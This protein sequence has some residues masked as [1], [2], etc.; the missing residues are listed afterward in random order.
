VDEC[1][2]GQEWWD[3]IQTIRGK[4]ETITTA[5]Q[6]L[7]DTANV[8]TAASAWPEATFQQGPRHERVERFLGLRKLLRKS[9]RRHTMSGITKLGVSLGMRTHHLDPRLLKEHPS[10]A[11][12]SED[13]GSDS[14]SDTDV[15]ESDNEDAKSVGRESAASEGD[16]DE[17]ESDIS[18]HLDSPTKLTRRRSHGDTMRG[19]PPS[20]KS[21]GEKEPKVPELSSRRPS[22]LN[23]A[24]EGSLPSTPVKEPRPQSSSSIPGKT[25]SLSNLSTSLKNSP[26]AS[27]SAPALVHNNEITPQKLEERFSALRMNKSRPVPAQTPER[28]ATL[29]R[30]ASMLKFSSKPVP[31]TR[32]ATEDGPGPSIMFTDTPSP[33]PRRNR[34]P[35][36]YRSSE[37]G[38]EFSVFPDHISEVSE[39]ENSPHGLSRQS[40][41][42]GSTYS[43]QGI[44]LSFNDLPCRAQHLILNELIRMQSADTAVMFTTLPSPMEGTSQSEEAC[45]SYLSDLE[46]LCKDCPP[47]LLV[48]SNSMTVTMSL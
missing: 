12:A 9:K 19:P 48:H 10:N 30:H 45:I 8:F 25:T 44:P 6:D 41:L 47:C 46:V 36:A 16:L 39:N 28:P 31:I 21:T 11:S 5:S 26:E 42:R 4:R 1:L 20:K 43:T 15:F 7:A 13:S 3:E 29:S 32:V 22:T 2:K 38:N 40:S 17:F 14:D 27:A 33:P 24:G 35:S 34:L 23:K 18:P 37:T